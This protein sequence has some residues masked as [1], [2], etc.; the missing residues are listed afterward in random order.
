LRGSSLKSEWRAGR[1]CVK[2]VCNHSFVLGKDLL[3]WLDAATWL[4]G[5]IHERDET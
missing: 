5:G 3:A 4:P 1:L 2:R